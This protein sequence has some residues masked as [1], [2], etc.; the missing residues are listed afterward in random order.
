MNFKNNIRS[1]IEYP[2]ISL[3]DKLSLEF[4]SDDVPSAY[5]KLY[6]ELGRRLYGRIGRLMYRDIQDV[7][8]DYYNT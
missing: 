8:F 3:K 6:N 2:N 7:R 5:E 4:V 1:K